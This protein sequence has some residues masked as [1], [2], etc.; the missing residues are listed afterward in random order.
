MKVEKVYVAIKYFK[1]FMVEY[2][3][4]RPSPEPKVIL[5]DNP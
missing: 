4:G 5:E 3:Q 2:A 1:K